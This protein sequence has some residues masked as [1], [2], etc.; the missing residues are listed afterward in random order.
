M[1]SNI[2]GFASYGYANQQA[3]TTETSKK[4][5]SDAL[6]GLA[7][8]FV[9]ADQNHDGLLQSGEIC[10]Y[11]QSLG[12]DQ[13]NSAFS[14]ILNNVQALSFNFAEQPGLT[15]T[16]GLSQDDLITSLTRV[17]DGTMSLDQQITKAKSALSP[18]QQTPPSAPATG[19][20]AQDSSMQTT[21]M[22]TMLNMMMSMLQMMTGKP[23]AAP[24]QAV[25]P[26]PLNFNDNRS[27]Q[28]RMKQLV[29]NVPAAGGLLDQVFQL[30]PESP[31]S[32]QLMFQLV[33]MLQSAG[34]PEEQIKQVFTLNAIQSLNNTAPALVSQSQNLAP[35]TPQAA[36]IQARLV[37]INGIRNSLIQQ[38]QQQAGV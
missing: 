3:G 18:G 23:V 13:S 22:G 2:G 35:N 6:G 32:N 16:A 27:L 10:N 37:A 25:A 30:A 19:G 1:S 4:Q 15:N 14:K 29:S 34:I 24:Q 20:Q 7:R 21:L 38:V 8:N 5:E 31:Q 33:P 36:A 28:Q 26:Q 11:V 17:S 12:Q 9:Q